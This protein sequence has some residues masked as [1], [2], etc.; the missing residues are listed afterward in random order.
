MTATIGFYT[1]QTG[2][3]DSDINPTSQPGISNAGH[4][5][6]LV[7]KNKLLRICPYIVLLFSQLWKEPRMQAYEM[8]RIED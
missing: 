7:T 8:N 3:E 4:G 6:H 1:I 2:D 5:S